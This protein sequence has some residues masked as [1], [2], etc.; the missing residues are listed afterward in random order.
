MAHHKCL[1]ADAPKATISIAF[2]G[3]WA[4]IYAIDGV[5]YDDGTD[6]DPNAPLSFVL[7]LG[8]E[9]DIFEYVIDLPRGATIRAAHCLYL[10]D[11]AVSE[12]DPENYGPPKRVQCEHVTLPLLYERAHVNMLAGPAESFAIESFAFAS[13]ASVGEEP[14]FIVSWTLR[15]AR[16]E[17]LTLRNTARDGWVLDRGGSRSALSTGDTITFTDLIRS[18]R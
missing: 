4:R 15:D 3:E 12:I 1:V 9:L 14:G 13:Q 8:H 17:S 18:N 2:G 10:V 11:S 16:G 7:K 5:G 6:V